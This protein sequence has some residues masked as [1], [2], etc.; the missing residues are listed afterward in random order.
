MKRGL[1]HAATWLVVLTLIVGLMPGKLLL[2]ASASESATDGLSWP[3][4]GAI[5]LTKKASPAGK[6][7]QWN[8]TLSVEGKN[9]TT[10][11]DVVLVIDRSG[12]MKESGRL[13]KAKEAANE[14]VRNL[15]YDGSTNRIAVVAF[16]ESA[17]SL[18][19]EFVGS[20]GLGN[21]Q[22][23]INSKIQQTDKG[24]N[25]QAGVH[26]AEQLLSGSQATN[27]SIILLSDGAP[28][29]SFKAGKAAAFDW[30]NKSGK[31][32]NFILSNFDYGKM[33]GSNGKYGLK[34]KKDDTYT[35]DGYEVKDN[36]IAALSEGKAVQEEGIGIYSIGLEV[37]N[38]ADAEYVLSNIQNK[39]YYRA[40]QSEL[41]EV[42]SK[43]SGKISYAATNATVI[44][45]MGGLF[46]LVGEPKVSQGEMKWNVKTE[47][48]TW[49][50]GTVNEGSPAT[51]TYTVQMDLSKNPL[52]DQLYP[53]NG[54]TTITYTDINGNRTAKEFEVP[55]VGINKGSIT[56]KGYLTNSAG[57]PINADGQAVE[58]PDLAKQLYSEGYQENG[59][60]ALD[61]RKKPYSIPAKVLTGYELKAGNNPTSVTLT[62]AEPNPTIWFG[63]AVTQQ[64]QQTQPAEPAPSVNPLPAAPPAA[65]VAPLPPAPPRL[66]KEE[67]YN[68]IFGYT[69]GL[70]KPENNISREEVATIFYRLMDDATRSDYLTGTTNSFK[71]VGVTRWSSKYIA[72]MENAGIITGYADGLYRPEQPITRA[73]FAAIASRFDNLDLQE[74]NT[75]SDIKG[76]WAEKYIVSAANKGWING[77]MDGTFK[78]DQFI[79]RAEAM[80]L[81]N[82]ELGRKVGKEGIAKGA[83]VWPDNLPAAWYYADV[84]EATNYHHY[85]RKEDH[86]ETWSEVLP[87]RI[88]P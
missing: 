87:D 2:R 23:L 64:T 78:P 76:T 58:R 51:L 45:P 46:N 74:N 62:A 38:D 19:S 59:K 56:Y 37:G 69:D 66:E 31:K 52:S 41:A 1:K 13:N 73:E 5:N 75:F 12:S 18:T 36:G 60:E 50:V 72:T 48:F 55:E 10:T 27:K 63:Y 53:T 79:T 14:F 85:S 34:Q 82:S 35:V 40:S 67:H 4:P 24:T 8:I 16:D 83:K 11:S 6:T 70:V 9:I 33:I 47:T 15:L 77:Y 25:I 71:D 86:S 32:Y 17:A 88:Y 68:Y 28:T 54:T 44:D 39:G 26:V 81:I 30:P 29:N 22:Q 20:T 80:K 21:L 42:F 3:T 7:N 84:V 61:I 43:L 49:D 65:S 57:K